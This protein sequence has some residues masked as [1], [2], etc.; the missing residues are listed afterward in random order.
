M[1]DHETRQGNGKGA[2]T[3]Q[4][5]SSHLPARLVRAMNQEFTETRAQ[6]IARSRDEA[7]PV[8]RLRYHELMAS[9]LI[10]SVGGG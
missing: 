1:S 9:K 10:E 3:P 6:A 8:A 2:A 7:D 4:T 5:L